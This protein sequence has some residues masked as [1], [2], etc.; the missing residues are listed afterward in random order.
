[1]LIG[2]QESVTDHSG[3]ESDKV[4]SSWG[5]LWLVV[6]VWLVIYA[7]QIFYWLSWY[8]HNQINISLLQL[9]FLGV[10]DWSFWL[11]ATPLTLWVARHYPLVRP[12]YALFIHLPLS[13]V[14][15]IGA[16]ALS[17]IVR[18][19]IEPVEQLGFADLVTSRLYIEGGW[20][21]MFYWFVAGAYFAV[22]YHAAYRK[23]LMES[24]QLQLFSESLQ[25]RLI[26]ARL[27]TLKVQLRPHFLF[28]ALHSVSSLMESSVPRAR[29][30]LIDLAEL[31]R[32]A[33]HISDRDTHPLSDEFDWLEKYLALEAIRFDG[34]LHWQ[35]L[36]PKAL[37]SHAI[38]CLLI[39]PLV[40]N[41]LKHSN[42]QS[43]DQVD[44]IL[45]LEIQASIENN[46]VSIV[47]SN[48]GSDLKPGWSEGY[49]L[50]FVR[51]SLLTHSD[52]KAGIELHNRANGGVIAKI[53]WPLLSG[54]FINPS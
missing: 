53:I 33:L 40:E 51:E 22:D 25:R 20:Y 26:E 5:S 9:L 1:M 39:Q 35:L 8:S 19:W 23:S 18:I 24:L 29:E 15:C 52:D 32:L 11:F 16:L 13:L 10:L 3:I 27:N 43:D 46:Q 36:L 38:P 21:F 17:S 42:I 34:Q 44:H 2:M 50:R 14:C 7:W 31:L 28:N 30:M 41:A 47:V 48:N 4:T 54:Q 37:E 6:M 12:R 45:V 49:G